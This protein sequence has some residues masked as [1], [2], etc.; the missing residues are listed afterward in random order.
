MSL[1]LLAVADAVAADIVLRN[2][3]WSLPTPI[4]QVKRRKLPIRELKLLSTM[5]VTVLPASDAHERNSRSTWESDIVID[6]LVEQH[7][8]DPEG[9]VGDGLLGLA[10]E[11]RDWFKKTKLTGRGE[12]PRSA[13]V[14]V[15]FGRDNLKDHSVVTAV[16]R[17]AYYAGVTS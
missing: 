1:T 9:A 10:G 13:T 5:Q 2:G 8:D 12:Q 7:V 4:A 14:I 16:C 15:P 17:I 3:S 11:F 6:V